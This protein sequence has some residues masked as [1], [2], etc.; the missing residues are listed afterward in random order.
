MVRPNILECMCM[1][2]G[3]VDLEIESSVIFYGIKSEECT[4]GIPV[5]NWRCVDVVF[6]K[7]V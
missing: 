2:S 1:S 5:L 7:V 4:S 3:V 6:L